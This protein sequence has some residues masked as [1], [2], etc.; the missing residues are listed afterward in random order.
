MSIVYSVFPSSRV[1]PVPGQCFLEPTFGK[2]SP[3]FQGGSVG[4]AVQP[5]TEHIA[6]ADGPGLANEDKKGRLKGI[7]GIVPVAQDTATDGQDHG[8]MALHQGGKG[9]L[10]AAGQEGFQQFSVRQIVAGASENVQVANQPVQLPGWHGASVASGFLYRLVP[11][12]SDFH[13][14]FAMTGYFE[15]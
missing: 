14:S 12:D 3:G 8:S 4:D 10:V 15:V 5:A 11:A 6:L 9:S 7:F 1:N 2:G 13:S